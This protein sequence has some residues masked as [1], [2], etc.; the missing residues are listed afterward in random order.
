M[1]I[2]NPILS[3]K[4]MFSYRFGVIDDEDIVG[5]CYYCESIVQES[6]DY[7]SEEHG[8]FCDSICEKLYE[9]SFDK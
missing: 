9:E 5:E 6:Q 8:L 4:N 3:G 2:E 1:D 7:R